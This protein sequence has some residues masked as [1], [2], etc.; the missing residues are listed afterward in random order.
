MLL[1][2]ADCQ[3]SNL[4]MPVCICECDDALAGGDYSLEGIHIFINPRL[5]TRPPSCIQQQAQSELRLSLLHDLFV[6]QVCSLNPL[7]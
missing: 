4:V 6:A 1:C 7:K 2:T 5:I 3:W